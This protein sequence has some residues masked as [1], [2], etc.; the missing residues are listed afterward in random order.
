MTSVSCYKRTKRKKNLAVRNP[1][2]PS[3]TDR[4]GIILGDVGVTIPQSFQNI[5]Y[6]IEYIPINLIP[7]GTHLTCTGKQNECKQN[8]S[9][10]LC[11]ISIF[12]ENK[13]P[14]LAI[15]AYLYNFI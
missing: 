4:L 2:N 14:V 7:L 13:R 10:S 15:N 1:F 11:C 8:E 9:S 6:Q 3:S 5:L 12:H